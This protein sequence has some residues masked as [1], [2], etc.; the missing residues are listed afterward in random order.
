[1]PVEA[2]AQAAG[3]Y[4]FPIN[5][6]IRARLT[7]FYGEAAAQVRHAEAFEICEYG[8]QPTEAEIL[9]LFPMLPR[10]ATS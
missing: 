3:R 6:A 9:R 7:Y 5:D 1:D 4:T 2:A 10:R 8:G